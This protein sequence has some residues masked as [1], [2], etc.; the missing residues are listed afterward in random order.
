MALEYKVITIEDFSDDTET[1]AL[2]DV[3]GADDWELVQATFSPDANTGK[4]T[5]LCI[6]KK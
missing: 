3:Q 2:L 6:F 5:A 1:K 4:A